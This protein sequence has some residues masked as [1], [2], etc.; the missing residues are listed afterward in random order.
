MRRVFPILTVL[1]LVS[2]GVAVAQGPG[3]GPRPGPG[4]QFM[5]RTRGSGLFLLMHPTVQAELKLTN[6]QK[7]QLQTM[8]Q[9]QRQ[10]QMG[11]RDLPPEEQRAK[12]EQLQ[13]DAQKQVGALLTASQKK[14]LRQI[15]WQMAGADALLQ[16][17]VAGELK[18]TSEQRQKI[19]AIFR[20]GFQA[21]AGLRGQFQDPNQRQAAMQKMQELREQTS[22]KAFAVL[23]NAQLS[24]WKQIIGA[25][26]KIEPLGRPFGRRGTQ[27]S[28]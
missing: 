10:A 16:E 9:N 12:F 28:E 8:M 22:K 23:T 1:V 13:Q 18:L 7:S 14:R 20:D 19:Q 21:T 11:L 6:Q 26:V 3:P 17:E 24:K 27:T 2:A 15:E 25:P 4:R 5:G